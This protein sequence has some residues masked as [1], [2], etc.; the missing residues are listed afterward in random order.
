MRARVSK[1]DMGVGR[2]RGS[3][4]GFLR[5][6]PGGSTQA[7]SHVWIKLGRGER[8]RAC[9]C[10]ARMRTGSVGCEGWAAPHCAELFDLRHGGLWEAVGLG[11]GERAD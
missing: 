7:Q 10:W 8:E 11:E 4:C 6:G 5:R 9:A 3:E 2:L 1:Q